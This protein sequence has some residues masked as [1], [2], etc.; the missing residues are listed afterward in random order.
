M[1]ESTRARVEASN[2]EY[3]PRAVSWSCVP[4]YTTR[5]SAWFSKR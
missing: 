1:T 2:D 5:F 4:V 3:H